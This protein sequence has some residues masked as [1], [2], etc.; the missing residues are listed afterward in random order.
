MIYSSHMHLAYRDDM[1]FPSLR[2]IWCCGFFFITKEL[3]WREDSMKQP[4]NL[5]DLTNS[6]I[7]PSWGY[8]DWMDTCCC[9]IRI[10]KKRWNISRLLSYIHFQCEWW[11][12]RIQLLEPLLPG[13]TGLIMIVLTLNSTLQ[14][15]IKTWGEYHLCVHSCGLCEG[16]LT[17]TKLTILQMGWI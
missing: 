7:G 1:D 13:T 2:N 4:A 5:L 17:S 3:A 16:H 12:R 9:L 6:A 11:D 14:N 15:M 8:S 10:K